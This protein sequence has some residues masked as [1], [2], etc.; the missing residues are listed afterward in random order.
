MDDLLEHDDFGDTLDRL[1]SD[2]GIGAALTDWGAHTSIG[3]VRLENEDYWGRAGSQLFAVADGMGGMAGGRHASE[4]AVDRFLKVDPC[5][6][7]INAI[8]QLNRDVRE[9]CNRDGFLEAGTTLTGL[10]IEP[11]RCLTINVGDSRAYRLRSGRLEL[12]TDDHTV[13]AMLDRQILASPTPPLRSDADALTSYIGYPGELQHANIGTH[14]TRP[15]DRFLLC[16]DGVYK[17]L[18]VPTL[19]VLL[20]KLG[21]NE[22]AQNIVSAADEAG[23]RDNATAVVVELG[24]VEE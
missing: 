21:C 13:R 24:L 9:R 8:R 6:G 17:Q 22:A 12:I 5:S 2:V 16:T 20:G 7:W 18:A 3:R 23:G 1:R 15:G 4:H 10:V 14:S 19:T 11:T